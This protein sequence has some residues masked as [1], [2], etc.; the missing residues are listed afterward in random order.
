MENGPVRVLIVSITMDRGGAE[1]LVMN[2]YRSLDR[3][4]VQFD[5]IL[6]CNYRSAY[7]DEIESLGGKIYH[8]PDFKIYNEF[9]YRRNFR[10]FFITHPEY[11]VIHSHVNNTA[12]IFL[13]EANK[14]GLHTIT[15]SHCTSNGSG[16]RAW[17]RD[18]YRRNL[19]KI[20]EY[21]FACSEEA[22]KWHF[23]KRAPYTVIKNGIDTEKFRFNEIARYEIRKELN[24][25]DNAPVLGHVGRFDPV[26]NHL[27]ILDVFKCLCQKHPDARLVLTGDGPTQK[28]VE[29]AVEQAGMT[30]RVIFTGS[31]QDVYRLYSAFDVF[32][33]PSI[34]EGLPL[35]LIEA[36]CSGLPCVISSHL[37]DEFEITDLIHRTDLSASPEVWVNTIEQC[38]G[39]ERKDNSELIG[40]KGYDIR[41]TARML[42]DFYTKL[43]SEKRISHISL[44]FDDGRKD[45]IEAVNSICTPLLIPATINITTGYIDGSASIMPTSK[46]ALS[47]EEVRE[48]YRNPLVEIALHGDSHDNGLEEQKKCYEK[49]QNWLGFPNDTAMGFASPGCGDLSQFYR[50]D[51]PFIRKVIYA[52]N[53]DRILNKKRLRTLARK[54][55]RLIPSASLYAFAFSNSFLSADDYNEKMLYSVIVLNG[56]YLRQVKK[57]VLHAVRNKKDLILCFHSI[58]TDKDKWSWNPEKFKKLC[59]YLAF[60]RD[61]QPVKLCK[62]ADMVTC[63]RKPDT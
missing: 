53:G 2:I 45:N 34:Y 27:F 10:K 42:Q 21:R 61:R 32:I 19:Y 3:S 36:Q 41:A 40:E 31:R 28:S 12:S 22:G 48:L 29:K 39:K 18:F 5:F 56:T 35:T 58:D 4:K 63:Y 1:T 57:L 60:L 47:I 8:L 55:S 50:T 30:D 46:P 7:E 26:K 25:P 17:I 15:H 24:I 9:S 20:A 59:Q 49:L 38:I 16:P 33:F 52:R 44:S 23:R 37:T 62:T 43:H 11:H 51:D 14:C 13:D 54:V 6:H